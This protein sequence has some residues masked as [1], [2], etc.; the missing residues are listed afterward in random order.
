MSDLSPHVPDGWQLTPL[1]EVGKGIRGVGYEPERDLVSGDES[2][3]TRLLR[4]NN[5]ADGVLNFDEIQRV[6]SAVVRDDQYLRDGDIVICGAN[7]SKR[8]VGKAALFKSQLGRRYTF[9]AFM[10][11]FRTDPTKA[12]P[13]FVYQLF[14]SDQYRRHVELAL[15]GSSINNL[16]SKQVAAFAFPIPE[17]PEQLTIASALSDAD[18]LIECLE[19]L[20]VKKRNVKK[21]TAQALLS[22]ALRLPGHGDEWQEYRLGDFGNT[23]AGLTGKTG[24]DFGIGE[25]K[26]V[27]FM[28]VIGNTRLDPTLV[29]TVNL[30]PGESQNRVLEGDLL[31][32]GSSETPTEVGFASAVTEPLEEVYLNS[33]CFGFRPH[34]NSELDPLY[35]AYWTRSGTGRRILDVLAQGSTRYNISKRALLGATFVCPPLSEQR[36]IAEVLTDMDAEIEAL[37]KRLAKTRDLKT[38]MAQELLSGRTR[39]V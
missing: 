19:R 11:C 25:S 17:L 35:F 32:N 2:D 6:R 28:N 7:G 33:F 22:G 18:R 8:L 5:V 13:D 31:F 34:P 24:S 4:A 38:G 37:E 14:Q 1:S 3:S 9:G 21:G 23:Y 29:Q 20:I 10:N 16:S 39:L 30:L 15:S 26:F 12:S 27:T 36:V